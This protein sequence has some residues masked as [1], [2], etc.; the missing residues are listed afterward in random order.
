MGWRNFCVLIEKRGG[1]SRCC[2][3]FSNSDTFNAV[4]LPEKSCQGWISGFS[5]LGI[6]VLESTGTLSRT[7]LFIYKSP[8]STKMPLVSNGTASVP[9]KRLHDSSRS[10]ESTGSVVMDS[11]HHLFAEKLIPVLVD[12]FLQAP[13]AEKYSIFPDIIQSLRRTYKQS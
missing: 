13:A 8:D 11:S 1:T 5:L 10:S 9:P 6:E 2:K 4:C 7:I 3:G 12:L